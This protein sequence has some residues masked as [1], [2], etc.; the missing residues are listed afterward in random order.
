MFWELRRE[1]P[2]D[3]TPERFERFLIRDVQAMVNS[4]R[5]RELRAA[6]LASRSVAT[7]TA[8]IVAA[9]RGK[10]NPPRSYDPYHALNERNANRVTRKAARSF[11]SASKADLIP[12]WVLAIAPM[13]Q[14]R[15]AA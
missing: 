12:T 14:I 9:L 7:N 10:W 3:V 6:M 1:Y 11:L 13:E 15:A 4:L 5:D 8:F 2:H